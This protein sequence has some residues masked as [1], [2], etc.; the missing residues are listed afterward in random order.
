[1]HSLPA[2]LDR[3]LRTQPRLGA[4]VYLATGAVV[5]GDVQMGDHSSVWYNAVARGDINRIVIGAG[6]NVQDNAVLHVADDYPCLL[7]DYVTVGHSAVV[8]AC[9]IESEVLVGM[10]AVILDGAV[11]GAQSIIGAHAL[12]TQGTQ[13]PAGSL[14]L[15][16]PARVVREL[17]EHERKGLKL[18]ADK[19]VENAKYCLH[20][21]IQI[22]APLASTPQQRGQG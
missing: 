20:H 1:M 3:Y 17:T 19:Y 12:V 18:W 8:H 15:G 7:G 22:G 16:A 14:L 10:G 6:T 2:R 11:I 21:R 5:I 4:G 13:V 9:T